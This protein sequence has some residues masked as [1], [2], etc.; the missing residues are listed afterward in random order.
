MSHGKIYSLV[1]AGA[2]AFTVGLLGL[3]SCSL[4]TP[5]RADLM[6]Y[7]LND[8]HAKETAKSMG[9]SVEA[10]CDLLLKDDAPDGSTCSGDDAGACQPK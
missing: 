6:Q 2:I 1:G 9:M 7:C 8:P 3:Q 4:F 10:L 5:S